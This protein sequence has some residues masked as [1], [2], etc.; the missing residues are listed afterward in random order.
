MNEK[1]KLVLQMGIFFILVTG[2][3]SYIVLNE[4]KYLIL[5]PKVEEKLNDYIDKEFAAEKA[6]L[7]IGKVKYILEDKSY[8][9]KLNNSKNK[10]LY[11]YVIYKNKKIT[12]T[13]KKDY[14]EGKSLYDNANNKYQKKFKNSKLVFIKSLDK[15]PN[16]IYQQIIDDD[17]MKLPIYSI[18]TELT[19]DKHDL[20]TIVSIINDFYIKNKN[21]GYNPK[22]YEI[23]IVDKNDISFS[24]K[25]SGLTKEL[26]TNNM[27]E[28]VTA[29]IKKDKNIINIYNIEYEYT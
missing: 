17:I 29:I 21:L 18:T 1:N 13:F 20:K 5:T 2:A 25:I 27:N 22:N 16:T 26:I 6:D 15:Y 8:K 11:F 28:I 7:D 3:F 24:V 12:D 10:N 19:V 9:I 4:K 14:Q 23:I